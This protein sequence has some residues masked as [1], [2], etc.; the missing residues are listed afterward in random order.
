[1]IVVHLG[2]V[3]PWN[4]Y[5][6]EFNVAITVHSAARETG[7]GPSVKCPSCHFVLIKDGRA[8]DI[9]RTEGL[10]LALDI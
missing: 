7:S 6:C 4:Y 3:S 10:H 5:I 8:E 2:L 9:V 1:M